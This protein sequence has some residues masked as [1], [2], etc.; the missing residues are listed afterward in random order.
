MDAG[1]S[2]HLIDVR[3]PHEHADFNIGGILLPLGRVQQMDIDDIEPLKN[4]EVIVY[5]RSGNRS[6]MASMMTRSSRCSRL[7]Q[8]TRS[9]GRERRPRTETST[10]MAPEGAG[11]TSCSVSAARPVSNASGP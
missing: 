8:W 7:L 5:C 2:L 10:S 6:G 4:E 11:R 9:P 3:E 1:E